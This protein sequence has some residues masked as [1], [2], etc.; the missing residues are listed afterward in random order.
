MYMFHVHPPFRCS[1]SSIVVT[2]F[3][4]FAFCGRLFRVERLTTSDATLGVVQVAGKAS[5]EKLGL[6]FRKLVK[7]KHQFQTIEK[8]KQQQQQ[9]QQ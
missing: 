8:I 1:T 7:K 3:S 9:R 2:A 4:P 5:T 6:S